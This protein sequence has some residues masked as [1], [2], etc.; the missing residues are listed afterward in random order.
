MSGSEWDEHGGFRAGSGVRVI[1]NR[2][3]II[4]WCGRISKLLNGK[5]K[6]EKEK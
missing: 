4:N 5:G 1:V 2:R 3:E 6:N